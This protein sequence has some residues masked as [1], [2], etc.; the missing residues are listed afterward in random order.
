MGPAR[1]GAH[2]SKI[3]TFSSQLLG[4]KFHANQFQMQL[5]SREPGDLEDPRL[6]PWSLEQPAEGWGRSDLA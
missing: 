5:T 6:W 2:R 4:C 3:L 1:W